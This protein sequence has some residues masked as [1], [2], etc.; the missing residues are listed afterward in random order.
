MRC[1]VPDDVMDVMRRSAPPSVS[2]SFGGCELMGDRATAL[3]ENIWYEK[4]RGCSY[5]GGNPSA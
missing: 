1:D 4:I 2:G 5:T 3:I